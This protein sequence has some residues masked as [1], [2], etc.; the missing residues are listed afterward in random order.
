MLSEKIGTVQA[1]Q[2]DALDS[3]QLAGSV[4]HINLLQLQARM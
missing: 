2:T 1:Q 3:T 4:F